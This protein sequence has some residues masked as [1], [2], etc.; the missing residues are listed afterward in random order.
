MVE[1]ETVRLIKEFIESRIL[2]DT[3]VS[4]DIDTR[5]LELG[6]L[7]SISTMKLVAFIRESFG[8]LE[9]PIDDMLAENFVNLAAIGELVDRL[10]A[11]RS[12][13]HV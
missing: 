9:V 1:T 6:I 12:E 4:I 7:T 8:G 11:E 10:D 3:E 2:Q 5:L 13:T